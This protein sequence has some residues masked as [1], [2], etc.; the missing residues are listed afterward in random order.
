MTS[1]ANI[2]VDIDLTATGLITG[3]IIANV[4]S[5]T[6]FSITSTCFY[7][8][9]INSDG[10]NYAYTLPQNPIIGKVYCVRNDGASTVALFPGS[11]N[12]VITG[13]VGALA[14]GAYT[15][16]LQYS[17]VNV[18][19]VS[20]NGAKNTQSGS[21]PFNNPL[22]QWQVIDDDEQIPTAVTTLGGSYYEGASAVPQTITAVQII[23]PVTFV[24]ITNQLTNVLTI[25]TNNKFKYIGTGN[26]I[27]MISATVSFNTINTNAQYTFY[28]RVNGGTNWYGTQGSD[29][30][31][32]V[33]DIAE[34]CAYTI[35]SAI[36]MVP[37]DYFEI[38]VDISIYASGSTI[39][40]ADTGINISRLNIYSSNI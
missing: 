32:N 6:N 37:N 12:S 9:I 23:Q 34:P 16:I 15:S 1:I 24:T 38:M 22:I 7:S 33:L 14:G 21:N 17:Y 4:N 28:I 31:Q 19:A 8:E 30:Q 36:L 18:V 26:R 35:S 2:N 11:S 40:S 10:G 20:S 27:W 25:T 29:G 13:L 39:I 3:T 5:P